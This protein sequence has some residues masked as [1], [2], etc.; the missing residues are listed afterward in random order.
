MMRRNNN[1]KRNRA[2]GQ[3]KNNGSAEDTISCLVLGTGGAG[4]TLLVRKIKHICKMLLNDTN[5]EDMKE[6][7]FNLSTIVTTGMEV[8]KVPFENKTL[9]FREVGSPLLMMW[10]TYF[11]KCQIILYVVSASNLGQISGAWMEFLEILGADETADKQ[12]ILV[13]NKLDQC[14][15]GEGAAA[16]REVFRPGELRRAAAQ[17]LAAVETSAANGHGL[18]TLL[19]QIAEFGR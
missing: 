14:D 19:Q 12:I 16:A 1:N 8:T 7:I 6:N 9:H 4:K 10:P 15:P 18:L 2:S 3:N 13:F 17:R 11:K 5:S